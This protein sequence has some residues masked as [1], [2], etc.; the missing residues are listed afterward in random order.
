MTGRGTRSENRTRHR[1][2]IRKTTST[3]HRSRTKLA[4]FGPVPFGLPVW[5]AEWNAPVVP[6]A[7]GQYVRVNPTA[8]PAD[9]RG[10]G[11]G[12]PREDLPAGLRG[13]VREGPRPP[14]DLGRRQVF[15]DRKAGY[16]GRVFAFNAIRSDT[17]FRHFPGA[18]MTPWP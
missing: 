11:V 17:H 14:R 6:A 13:P 4:T 8:R 5:G 10:I 12:D 3:P 9:D 18:G 16:D 15:G 7:V 1:Q 2:P